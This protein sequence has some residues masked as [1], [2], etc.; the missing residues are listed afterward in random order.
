MSR[1]I[2][3]LS[4]TDMAKDARVRRQVH[5]LVLAGYTVSTGAGAPAMMEN[6]TFTPIHLQP[7]D[8]LQLP[9]PLRKAKSFMI[10]L[11]NR[12]YRMAGDHVKGYW[13]RHRMMDLAALRD[14]PADL[15]IANDIDTLPLALALRGSGTKVLFDAHEYHPLQGEGNRR[16]MASYHAR[17]TALCKTF[18]PQADH[19]FTVSPGIAERYAALTGTR[20]DVLTNAPAFQRQAPALHDQGPIHLV[21]H[22]IATRQRL[23]LD[24]VH[25][26]D[27][28]GP[29]YHMH[30]HLLTDQDPDYA[31]AVLEACAQRSNISVHPPLAPDR[32]CEAIR[33]YDI[34][35]HRLS[36][37]NTNHQLA[38]PNKFFEFIQAR[39]A[40]A[41]SPSPS[42]AEIIRADGLGAVAE[43]HSVEALAKAIR[44]LD[45]DRIAACK[46][47]AHA[48]AFRHSAEG[49]MR[50]L[51]STVARLTGLPHQF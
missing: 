38:L 10:R 35:V 46:R 20:P 39:L 11:R 22:G 8:H 23:T 42:M 3:I 12:A 16:W 40:I 49:N 31:R 27:G 19:C 14:V 25:L 17:N 9:V 47:Q 5:E 33:E 51:R 1:S 45:R 32:I 7:W 48:V 21:H 36:A 28:L 24:L 2:L 41:A 43:D 15:I 6:G 29:A 37:H 4:Y 13:S 44:S 30:F 50:L 34:G 26:M 18:M